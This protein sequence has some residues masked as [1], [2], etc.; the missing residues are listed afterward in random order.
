MLRVT[1]KFHKTL[2]KFTNGYAEATFLV[3][4][5]LDV[6]RACT[7]LFPKFEKLVGDIGL[8]KTKN[9]EIVMII[10]KK[11]LEPDKIMMRPKANSIINLVPVIFGFGKTFA[12]IGIA[13]LF[14]AL[15]VIA[16]PLAAGAAAGA[17]ALGAGVAAGGVAGGAAA[18][19]GGISLASVA[20]L[21]FGIAVTLVSAL[22]APKPVPAKQEAPDSS[23]RRNN[24]L[25][26]GLANTFRVGT[27]IPLNYGLIRVAGQFISGYVKTINHGQDEVIRVSEQFT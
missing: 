4:S 8:G 15:I 26:D 12:I 6:M 16:A 14:V 2:Q 17:G 22:L 10:D 11:P 24:D 25:F 9:Q 18:I 3:D 5:Y 21:L 27:G 7:S 23:Q 20:G 19:G 13:L 1:V